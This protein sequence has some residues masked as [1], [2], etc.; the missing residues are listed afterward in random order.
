MNLKFR[1]LFFAFTIVASISYG[2]NITQKKIVLQKVFD[3]I[4]NAYGNAKAPPLLQLIPKSKSEG[5]PAFYSSTPV[6]TIKIEEQAFDICMQLGDDGL[7]ALSIILSHEL[8][9]YY[10]DH[11]WCSDFSYAIK[12]SQ[13]GKT[14]RDLSKADRIKYETQADNFGFY[15]SC[16]SGYSPFSIYDKLIDKIYATYKLPNNVPGYPTKDERKMIAQKAQEKIRKLYQVF[17][18]GTI[19]TYASK[20]QEAISCFNYLNKFFPSRENYNNLGVARLLLAL[21]LKPLQAV[22]FIYPVEIDAVSRL[23]I[24]GTRG[25]DEDRDARITDLLQAAKKDFETAISLDP[26]YT[27]AYINL[28]CVYDLLGNYEA[29]IGRINEITSKD[30]DDISTL[31][32]KAIAYAHSENDKKANETFL[33]IQNL[34][35]D[36][37]RYNYKMFELSKQ[38]LYS[39]ESF[40]QQWLSRARMDSSYLKLVNDEIERAKNSDSKINNAETEIQISDIPSFTVR[41]RIQKNSLLLI[42][43]DKDEQINIEKY[44]LSEKFNNTNAGGLYWQIIDEKPLVILQRIEDKVFGILVY[45]MD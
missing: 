2:Q 18:A 32:I 34:T 12:N 7:N 16:I 40:K 30:K 15:Y 42:I 20:Y 24:A 37:V 9:H 38:S 35:K 21:R 5:N 19:L 4:V 6:P 41:S 26:D 14:L 8:A 1:I 23:K 31:E 29:A 17:E 43:Q 33:Q 39:S 45:E 44:L 3:N 10:N 22:E 13:L 25:L 28:A 36:T 11:T 27:K